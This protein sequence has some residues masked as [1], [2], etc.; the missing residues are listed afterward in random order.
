MERLVNVHYIDK[1]A[2]L[3]NNAD[4]GEEPLVFDTS[5]SYEDVV[6]KVRQ[7]LKWMD[8]NVDVKLIGRYDVGVGAKSRLKSMPITS[9]L[10]WDVYKE[11]VSQSEDK[12]LE[13]F[14]TKVESPRFTFDLNRH[15]SSPMD[16]M[17][18]RTMVPLVEHRVVV[19]APNVYPPARPRVPSIKANE[20]EL[21]APNA[22]SQPP[23]SQ[24]NEV[25]VIASDGVIQEDEDAYDDDEEQEEGFHGNDVGDLDAYIAQKDMDRDLPFR[26][27]YAYD[28]D[29][30]GPVEQ[31][32][33]D[34]FTKEENQIHFELT[35]L[36][37]R[38]HL[39]KDLSL[40]HKAVVDGGM[41]MTAIEPTPC[42]DPGEPRVENEDENAYLKKGVKFLSLPMLKFWL[43]DYAI[44]N[45]RPFYV[46]H[47]DMKLRYTV[48]CEQEGCPWKVRARKLKE[49]EEWVLKSCVATH[50]CKPPSKRLR[51]THR[52][53]TSEYLGYKW[54]KD[55]GF[56][57][58]V[59]V[60]FLMRTVKKQFG[61]EVK[62]GKAWKAKANAIRML[63]GGYE[64]AYN[65]LPRLLAAIAHRNPGM[66]HVVEDHEGVFHRAFW[67]YG[68]CVEAFQHC[69]P[70]LSIDG[71][72][73]TGRYKGTLMVAMAHSSN[74]NVLPCA[75]ALVPSEHQD[76]WEWFMG[77]VRHNVIGA[78]EVCIIS[79][80]HHGIL[81]AM[82]IVIPGF[83]KLHH[84]WCMRHFVAN[85]Y[86][87]CKSK[88]LSKD[89]TH[90]CVAFT[91][92][93]F[94]ARYNKLFA[95]VNEGGKDFLTRN[96]S[97]K[98]KW[99]R[100]HDDGGW[101]YGDMTSNL[102]ECFNNVLKGAR[103]L[104]VTAIVEYTFFKLNEYFQR[105]SEET[106]KW[107]GEKKD[108]PEKVDEW[109][110][111]QA[112]KSSR[113]QVI[114]FD[115]IEM[116][117]QIDEPGG[118]TRDG[119]QYGGAAFEVK[120]KTRWCQCE[121]PSKYHWPCSHLITA[122]KARNI[123]VCD[124]KTVRMQ[125]FHVEATR[126][127]W[128]PRFHPFLDQSQWPEYHGPHIRPDPLLKVETKGRRRT[129]RF[130]GDMDDLAGYTGMKQFGSGHFME[131]PDTINCG[132]CGEG[133]HNERTCK[134]KKTKKRKTSR[135]GG[136]DGERGGRGDGGGGRGSTSV[137]G[138]SGGRRG[139]TKC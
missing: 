136:T 110:Q 5:P 58:T 137:R 23:T 118:T 28:S 20:V 105:H 33:E 93:G 116:I 94:D 61:Y 42:P 22:S 1:E 119:R 62:Y 87:A 2:F 107:I 27:Q 80:R 70:V 31:L 54:M 71:T 67:S 38:T 60:R 89:L 35:G 11:K 56:D 25:E 46:E 117:Y 7:V 32:D 17:S 44:R 122:A 59:K 74:D 96:L 47:S 52:Q 124:G 83:P 77:H 95:A 100:A 8:T 135:G 53:L 102:V 12:S 26:R 49:T 120:L 21:Y 111:L 88:E 79:D 130:R 39:F 133:G 66:F 4:T 90:V 109:L 82:D 24:A 138:G 129:K 64:E 106:A 45:H 41:R 10:H 50:R 86:R 29:D 75:F 36:Q 37:K 73:L 132:V 34:G 103:A 48:K 134:N 127:T 91:T 68:Q 76:N 6:A 125:E 139:S 84:R 65:Q 113:Q 15:V 97:E 78:R 112:S 13:L 128:A 72:F 131:A 19:D 121:R 99:A 55:I 114:I 101:R 57:P 43:S 51:K 126:L 18:E 115:R 14:A 16:D 92:Q 3:S 85:F 123:H 104:P 108:Y 63:Y 40:A 98:H 69:R 30:E 81:K 9:D